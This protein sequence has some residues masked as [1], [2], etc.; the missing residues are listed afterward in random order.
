VRA[1]AKEIKRSYGRNGFGVVHNNAEIIAFAAFAKLR[2][3]S[4]MVARSLDHFTELQTEQIGLSY[5]LN[6]GYPVA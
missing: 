6:N 3:Q 1:L 5:K 4:D 2:R